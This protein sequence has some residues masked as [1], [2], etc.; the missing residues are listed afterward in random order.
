MVLGQKAIVLFF[1]TPVPAN[2]M[3][4]FVHSTTSPEEFGRILRGPGT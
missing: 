2:K 3:E 1:L 4:F